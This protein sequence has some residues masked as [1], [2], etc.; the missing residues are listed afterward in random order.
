MKYE[1][2]M[3]IDLKKLKNNTNLLCK[4]YSDYQYK[5]VDLM[6]NGHGLGLKIIDTM[7]QSGIDYCLVGS[8]KEALEIRNFN[9][10][11]S[12][13][14]NCNITKEEI[15]DCINNNI[16]IT[17]F[18]VKTA[19]MLLD[20]KLKDIVKV[21]IVIDNGSNLI[22]IRTKEELDEVIS[23]LSKAKNIK[24][25]GIYT[26]I[27][28]LGVQDE[29]YYN[30][31]DNFYQIISKYINDDLIIH[32]NEPV[33]YHHKLKYVNGIRFDLSILGIEENINDDFF[34]SMKVKN[35]E[36]KHGNLEFPNIDLQLIFN[37]TSEVSS[38][39]FVKKGCIIGKSYIA[40]SDMFVALVP[41]GH[42]DG[43]T[44]AINY[45]GVNNY[46]RNILSDAI[47]Y[48]IIEVT[49]DVKPKDK[50][51]I[52][53]EERGIYDFFTSLKT[54]RYYLMSILNRNLEKVYINEEI[55]DGSYL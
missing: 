11:V 47:N 27:T 32:V 44:K 15:Y 28:T 45:V 40:K 5:F 34:S 38:T 55:K 10:K 24:L 26:E 53:N 29:F 48:I 9:K 13:L 33:M 36:K 50:V 3:E 51:Y 8:L 23:I 12:I 2:K 1:T 19:S 17:I 4:S 25:E 39:R 20:L 21:H 18:D 16:T 49:E 37:I 43:I 31:V 42:K 30:Q 14:L 22:G 6:D 46:K 52:L 7:N 35:I 54:N 41:I